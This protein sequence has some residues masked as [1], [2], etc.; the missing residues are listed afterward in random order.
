[1]RIELVDD[2]PA[3]AV[4]EIEEE[5]GMLKL[6]PE[7]NDPKF[8]MTMARL[9]NGEDFQRFRV[10]LLGD[11]HQSAVDRFRQSNSIEGA[12]AFQVFLDFLDDF[13]ALFKGAYDRAKGLE[14]G[15]RR[16]AAEEANRLTAPSGEGS[17]FE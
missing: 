3:G 6:L 15:V 9:S 5:E 10:Y 1:M 7:P 17:R 11:A 16:K 13:E 14:E 8:W 12:I 2:L 4:I